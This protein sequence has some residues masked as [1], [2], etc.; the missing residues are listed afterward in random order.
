[1]TDD[2]SVRERALEDVAAGDVTAF[3]EILLDLHEHHFDGVTADI[4][5]AHRWERGDGPI[6]VRVDADASRDAIAFVD[7]LAERGAWEDVTADHGASVNGWR[8][9]APADSAEKDADP[10]VSG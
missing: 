6:E 3:P 1:M 7:E 8:Y 2:R 10:G 5:G 9:Y 4:H